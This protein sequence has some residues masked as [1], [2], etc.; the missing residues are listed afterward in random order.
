[1]FMPSHR[2]GFGMPVLEAGLAGLP[3]L[4]TNVPV[5]EEIGEQDVT[6][7]NLE[8]DPAQLA[9][10]ILEWAEQDSVFRLRRRVRQAYT[11]SA[12]FDRDI[13]PLI[14]DQGVN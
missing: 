10:Q 6:V 3:V 14:D 4:C 5:A 8:K 9:E 12:I 11:W 7:F 13:R 2:E 1:M